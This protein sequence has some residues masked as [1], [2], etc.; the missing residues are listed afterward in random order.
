MIPNMKFYVISIIAIFAALGIGIYIGFTLDAQ[1]FVLEQK[2]DIV[3]KLE[4]RFDFLKSENQNLKSTIKEMDIEND[5]YKYFIESTY[6]EI[7]KNKLKDV[8]IAIIETKDDY[9]YSGVGQILGSAGANVINVTTITD[10]IMNEGIL[11]NIYNELGITIKNNKQ[12]PNAV[13][14]LTKSLITGK[15]SELIEKLVENNI[16]DIVGIIDEPIDYIIIAGGSV[17]EDRNR[18]NLVDKTI[19]DV[20]KGMNIPLIGIEKIKASYS[21]ME[22]YKSFRISTIDNIDTIMGKVS[23]ILAMEGRPGHYGVKHT[24]EELLP[25]LKLSIL[26]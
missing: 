14:E 24:A 10:N 18:I 5:N 2:E 12:I 21:Y 17:K 26:E 1:S 4:E 20:S 9:M 16:I 8:N 23:L 13:E 15:E 3:T 6:V 11:K 19:V 7:I 25:N 22:N